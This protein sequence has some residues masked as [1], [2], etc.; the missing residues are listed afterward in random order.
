M[1]TFK[2]TCAQ[3]QSSKLP[4]PV[5]SVLAASADEAKLTLARSLPSGLE[6]LRVVHVEEW[7]GFDRKQTDD[8]VLI[9]YQSL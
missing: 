2:V 8:V 4:R 7:P 3:K 9:G 5:Y 6:H 1:L